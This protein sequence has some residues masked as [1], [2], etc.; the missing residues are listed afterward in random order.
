VSANLLGNV[1]VIEKFF[2]LSA[3]SASPQYFSPSER[4]RRLANA[5]QIATRVF[6]R[7]ARTS[8]ETSGDL[9]ISCATT[10]SGT[11]PTAHRSPSTLLYHQTLATVGSGATMG[12]LFEYYRRQSNS[13]QLRVAAVTELSRLRP[14]ALA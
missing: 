6:Y 13:Q 8:K 7:S 14:D 3:A 9:N 12:W 11:R 4:S 1:E 2:S 10:A 5:T